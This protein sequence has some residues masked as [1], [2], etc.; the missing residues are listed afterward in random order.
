MA[1]NVDRLGRPTGSAPGVALTQRAWARWQC[2]T[3]PAWG[4]LGSKARA[5]KTKSSALPLDY[6]QKQVPIA[7]NEWEKHWKAYL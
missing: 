2:R 7:A 4:G 5:W 3:G 6:V 1:W